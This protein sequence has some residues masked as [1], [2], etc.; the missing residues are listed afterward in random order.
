MTA[1][2]IT[3]DAISTGA[4]PKGAVSKAAAAPATAATAVKFHLALSVSNL[5]AAVSFY[6]VFF[7][8]EPAKEH[9]DYAKFEVHEPPLVLSLM[10]GVLAPG[11]ALNHLG[12]RLTDSAALVDLQYR[13]EAAG[14]RTLREDNV[15]CC[16]SRQTKFWVTD[17]DR[18]LWELYILHEEAD[19]SHAEHAAVVA[20][21]SCAAASTTVPST[22]VELQPYFQAPS[23]SGQTVA[24]IIWQHV[25][26]QPVPAR[27]EHADKSVDEVRL[28]GTFNLA[29]APAALAGLLAEIRRVLRPAASCACMGWWP[30]GRSSGAPI[31]RALRRSSSTC[32]WS[33]SRPRRCCAG[34][35]RVATIQLGPEPCLEQDGVALRELRL[36]AYQ[37]A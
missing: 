4:R 21:H 13:L 33:R 17:P 6:R 5:A 29:L 32:R 11:G 10:P 1:D 34:F 28:E 18:T 20:T 31:C 24:P 30:N 27:I 9:A 8:Q 14:I 15:A 7:G 2:V 25:L 19:D 3:T 26:L 36:V 35:V 22:L 37:P 16:H 12:L 23:A